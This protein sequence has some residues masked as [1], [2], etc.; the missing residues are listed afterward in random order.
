MPQ[1]APPLALAGE[2]LIEWHGAQ[3][4]LATRAAGGA[5]R[6]A[7]AA[8]G[9]HATLFRARDKSAGAFTPLTPPL[10]HPPRLKRAFDPDGIFNPGR[11][12]PG[13]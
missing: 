9:G 1:T 2:Q 7:A 12:Y 11:L 3:R 13:L 8:V 10:A 4:W 5:V 6:D